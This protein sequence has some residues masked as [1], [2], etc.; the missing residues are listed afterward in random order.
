MTSVPLVTL[1][2][3]KRHLRIDIDFQDDDDDIALK[4]AAA[5]E[6]AVRYLDRPVYST[7]DALHAAIEAGTAGD[8]PIVCTDMIRA[9]ILLILGDLYTNRED[10]MTGT[11]TQLPTGAAACLRPMRRMGV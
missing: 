8:D 6:Q 11:V 2:Q 7:P 5:T 3:A 1:S 9:G 10:V 4:L